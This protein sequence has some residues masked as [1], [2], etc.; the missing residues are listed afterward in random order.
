MLKN[1]FCP[2]ISNLCRRDCV[3]NCGH[4]ITLNNGYS[5]ECELMAFISLQDAEEIQ[6]VTKEIA[7][8]IR[9]K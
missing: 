6:T 8:L 9:K 3:F 5:T 4:N 7:K 1:N 2:F